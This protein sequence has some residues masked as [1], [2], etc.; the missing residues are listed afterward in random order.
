MQWI[1]ALIMVV[2]IFC[3]AVNPAELFRSNKKEG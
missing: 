3:I 1:G 2:G